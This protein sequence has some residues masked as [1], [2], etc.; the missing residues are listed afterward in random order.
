[1]VAPSL[2]RIA[3]LVVEPDEAN[4]VLLTSTLTSFG[5]NVTGTDN[6]KSAQSVLFTEPPSLL[7]TDIFLGAYN[8]LHLVI[9]GQSMRPR[10]TSVVM[11]GSIDQ[12]LRRQAEALG[13]TLV[14]KPATTQEFFRALWHAAV[15]EPT[16]L[17]SNER[18][19][20]SPD[21]QERRYRKRR[22]DIA[23]FL[24]LQGSRR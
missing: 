9:L 8:G 11:S 13:T 3:A 19:A 20:A 24:L 17:E 7:V 4:R 22:R 5:F 2:S 21:R 18:A 6:F 10:M 14:Q 15:R 1:M 12:Y 23:T 16:L